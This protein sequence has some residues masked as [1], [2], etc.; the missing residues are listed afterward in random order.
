MKAGYTISALAHAVILGWGLLSFSARPLEAPDADP[1]VADVITETELS[2]ITAGA[3]TAKQT[4]TPTPVVDKAGEVKE[5]PK[6]PTLKVG[7]ENVVTSTAPPPPQPDPKPD[8]KPAAATPAP[9]DPKPADAKPAPPDPTPPA[10][11]EP[12]PPAPDPVAEAL[13]RAEAQK[14]QEAAKKAEAARKRREAK[15][16][17]EARKREEAKKREEVKMDLSRIETALLD[18][19]APQRQA[20]TGTLVNPTPS[21]G[22]ATGTASHLSQSE[23]DRIRAMLKQQLD[24]CWNLPA[25]AADAKNI[26]VK[27]RF[28]LNRDGS[29]A[30]QPVVVTQGSGPTFQ[31]FAE[32]ALKA[33][34][35]CSPL[36]LPAAEYEFW[37]DLEV[38]FDPADMY[39]G[40]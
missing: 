7:K 19:R 15:R 3:T 14:K 30:S 11:E 37:Q 40:G 9:P 32:S 29:L 38:N 36:R 23:L 13:K 27:V 24:P 4:P 12:P 33:V 8:P 5:P 26:V 34:R 1:I 6:D 28:S 35:N 18:K 20:V 16:R 25:G 22:T 39:P 31:V 21:L 10:A 17:E 2:K